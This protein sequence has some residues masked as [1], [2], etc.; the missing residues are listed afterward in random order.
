[1]IASGSE[2]GNIRIK[3]FTG[4]GFKVLVTKEGNGVMAM[5]FSPHAT[6]IASVYIEASGNVKLW[7]VNTGEL[8]HTLHHGYY[9]YCVSISSCG[10]WI[11]TG[12]DKMVWL[13][14]L[15]SSDTSQGWSCNKIVREFYGVVASMAW[16]PNTPEFVTGCRDGS[17]RMW[18][19]QKKSRGWSVQV[20]WN[21]ASSCLVATD[22]ILSHAVGLSP[23]D[24]QLLKQRGAID[25][26][27]SSPS[28]PSS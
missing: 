1:M 8:K 6:Y 12:C 16:R 17:T 11:A 2:D 20:V 28:I 5:A 26:S 9:V 18:R 25:E 21:V 13:W 3:T 7:D 27:F 14:S 23:I 19:L 15:S 4:G 24:Q 22:A 10:H